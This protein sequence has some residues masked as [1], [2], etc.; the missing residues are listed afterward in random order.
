MNTDIDE[1]IK[2]VD[3]DPE[4]PK[5]F[6]EEAKRI[7][8]GIAA[9]VRRIE[10]FGS[11][12]V[13]GMA[14]KPVVDLLVGVDDMAQ[15]HAVAQQVERLGYQ[16]FGEALLPGRVYLRQRGEVNFNVVIVVYKGER[17][18]YFTQVRDF[19]RSHPDEVKRYSEAK[20]AAVNAGDAMFLSYSYHK[21]PFLKDLAERASAWQPGEQAAP[22]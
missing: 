20:Q 22:L 16:N 14:G 1:P 8:A 9:K 18:C 12:S 15:A 10:H 13:P 6:R 5:L 21:G 4:W 17:W 3:Y 7:S 19:L 11:T 2:V